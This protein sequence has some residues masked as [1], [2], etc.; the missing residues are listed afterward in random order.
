M[1]AEAAMLNLEEMTEMHMSDVIRYIVTSVD[2]GHDLT[3]RRSNELTG[4]RHSPL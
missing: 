2:Q 3:F 4:R 1:N